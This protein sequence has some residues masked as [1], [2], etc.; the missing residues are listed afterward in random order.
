M[1]ACLIVDS[2]VDHSCSHNVT[3]ILLNTSYH[4]IYI[5][6]CTLTQLL[7]I[8]AHIYIIMISLYPSK[9]RPHPLFEP[10]LVYTELGGGGAGFHTGFF[11][12]GGTMRQC[13]CQT[14]K[15]LFNLNLNLGICIFTRVD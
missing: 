6:M 14:D 4:L 3:T 5:I 15:S 8:A 9:N 11:V 12:R 1:P 7:T 10:H 2:L 13:S